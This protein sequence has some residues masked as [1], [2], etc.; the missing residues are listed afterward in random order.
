LGNRPR[1]DGTKQLDLHPWIGSQLSDFG[2][3]NAREKWGQPSQTM[4]ASECAAGTFNC[5]GAPVPP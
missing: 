2:N 3:G 4:G 1:A 5:P